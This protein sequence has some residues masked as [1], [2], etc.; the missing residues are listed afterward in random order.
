[1][2]DPQRVLSFLDLAGA[3]NPALALTMGGAIAIA[4]PAYWWRRRQLASAVPVV[5]Q[6]PTRGVD[7]ELL[8]GSSVFG[9]GWGLSG[10]CPGPGL[11]L[12]TSG[13][14]QALEF[15]AAMAVG[16]RLTRAVKKT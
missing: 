2:T 7:R 11:I 3:W 5:G 15:V 4:A 8:V 10:I 12:L 13:R 1:M 16:M 6:S 9:I 14:V